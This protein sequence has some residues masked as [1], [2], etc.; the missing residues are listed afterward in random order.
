MLIED[1]VVIM[2]ILRK[3]TL[4]ISGMKSREA[5]DRRLEND[6]PYMVGRHIE[7]L[8]EYKGSEKSV[9]EG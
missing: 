4:N 9:T 6:L 7:P 1:S 8:N 5:K 3:F 2:I